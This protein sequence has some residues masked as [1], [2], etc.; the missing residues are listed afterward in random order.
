MDESPAGLEAGGAAGH[1]GRAA[2]WPKNSGQVS[3]EYVMLLA[4]LL[5]ILMMLMVVFLG[6]YAQQG[7]VAQTALA[8]HALTVLSA[9]AQAAWVGGQG[10]ERKVL[11]DLPP[12]ADLNRSSINGTVLQLYLLGVGDVSQ[13]L[14]FNVSGQWPATTG[15]A[16]MSAYNNGSAVLVRPAGRL[17]VNVSG[18]YASMIAGGAANNTTLSITNTANVSYTLAQVLSCPSSA[19]CT[20]DGTGGILAAGAQQVPVLSIESG[21]IGLRTGNLSISATPAA[22]SGLPDEVIV[23]PITIRVE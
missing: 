3:M 16:Y 13:S 9:Q 18:I 14:P 2:A 10:A 23:I 7:M 4:A 21:I 22:G 15:P 20:Y 17:V 12:S 6:Q 8:S 19:S 1:G 11:I 5:L